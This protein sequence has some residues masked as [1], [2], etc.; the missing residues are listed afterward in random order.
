MS[1]KAK[2]QRQEAKIILYSGKMYPVGCGV[3]LVSNGVVARAVDVAGRPQCED[4]SAG[5]AAIS[6]WAR[7]HTEGC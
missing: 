7:F 5:H 4:E 6:A 2:Q 1:G 3:L